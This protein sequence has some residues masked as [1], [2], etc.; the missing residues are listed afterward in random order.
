MVSTLSDRAECLTI[1]RALID[2]Y[3]CP[4]DIA[5]FC[6]T[7]EMSDDAGFFRLGQGA[8]CYGQSATGFRS[9]SFTDFLY[10]AIQDVRVDKSSLKLPFDPTNVIDNLRQERYISN[11]NHSWLGS[12]ARNVLHGSYYAV[13]PLMPIALRRQFQRLYF[14]GL[15]IK[16]FPHWPVDSSV[17][18]ILEKL[19]VISMKSHVVDEIPF[20]WFWPKGA[21]GC[22]LMTHDVETKSGRDFCSQ[23]MDIDDAFNIKASFQIVPERRYPVSIDFL[24]NIR[25]RRFE[26]NVHDLNHDGQLYSD[27]NDFLHR[28]RRINQ[29]GKEWGAQGFRAAVLYHNL[30]W[31]PA[32]EFS[33]DM[34][35][36]NVGHLDPQGGG[37]CT[38]FPYFIGKILELPVTATQDYSLFHVLRQYSVAL[39][40]TQ[41][42]LILE[43]HGLL[44][45]IVHPDYLISK[46]ANNVYVAL[47]SHLAELR[48]KQGVWIALPKEVDLWW[49][50]RNQMKLIRRAGH[51]QIEGEGKQRAQIAYARLDGEKLIYR[52]EDPS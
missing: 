26:V 21:P 37:C 47:L 7:G 11:S 9:A 31:Y 18:E 39:W 34:S 17:E 16:T 40:K 15:T 19:L 48:E 52:I 20:I 28:A 50:E 36:S 51:W 45:F 38:V 44:S 24:R 30:D 14:C 8:I 42:H 22:V 32:L 4:E 6:V 23:L 33:Y 13:R 35:V 25:E 29:Y 43:K 2:H 1:N 3:K 41:I 10:D 5:D 27:Q 46:K 12:I 49:R